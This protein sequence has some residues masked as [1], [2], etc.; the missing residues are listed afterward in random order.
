MNK[1]TIDPTIEAVPVKLYPGIIE[2]VK[3]SLIDYVVILIIMIFV[4]NLFAMFEEVSEG[5]R[6]IAF[7]LVFGF[8]DPLFTSLNGGTLGH[9]IIGIR[10]V[11]DDDSGKNISFPFAIV[12]YILKVL[13]GS[14]SLLTISSSEKRRAIHDMAVNSLVV[15]KEESN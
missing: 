9:S 8:Y 10:V 13:L 6:M 15:Y 5:T 2:R 14:I 1:E 11:K 12:R 3:A 7:V 4:G